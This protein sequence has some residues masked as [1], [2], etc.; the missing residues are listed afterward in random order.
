MYVCKRSNTTEVFATNQM[1]RPE[2]IDKQIYEQLS[3]AKE[4]PVQGRPLDNIDADYL[5]FSQ[6]IVRN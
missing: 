5:L 6:N 4:L 3:H 2:I 1:M